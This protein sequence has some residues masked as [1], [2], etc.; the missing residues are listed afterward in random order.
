MYAADT[1]PLNGLL[2]ERAAENKR[3]K[4]DRIAAEQNQAARHPAT[5]L[6]LK[7]AYVKRATEI[8]DNEEYEEYECQQLLETEEQ[9][10]V[11]KRW[12]VLEK[13]FGNNPKINVQTNEAPVN[14]VLWSGIIANF[15]L[16]AHEVDFQ[17]SGD[18][19]RGLIIDLYDNGKPY[20]YFNEA[21]GGEKQA[22]ILIY[23]IERGKGFKTVLIAVPIYYNGRL[24][25]G[26][27]FRLI[28]SL[29]KMPGSKKYK[30]E[31]FRDIVNSFN[32]VGAQSE[33]WLYMNSI[34][35]TFCANYRN[36]YQDYMQLLT[37]YDYLRTDNG[38]S[39]QEA[40]DTVFGIL[41]NTPYARQF[42]MAWVQ[43]DSGLRQLVQGSDLETE[44][45]EYFL[46]S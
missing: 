11:T 17:Y 40:V 6:E 42:K 13:Y 25:D 9:E 15:S 21:P 23:D 19:N 31:L 26:G 33:W 8:A 46:Q 38:V 37:F 32:L 4:A 14:N 16:F 10:R 34:R 1:D 22:K 35:A 12:S 7:K 3:L 43:Q 39:K 36:Y 41:K 20:V 45:S 30:A 29:Q 28:E 27:I 18:K 24:V 44:I 5:E 2:K